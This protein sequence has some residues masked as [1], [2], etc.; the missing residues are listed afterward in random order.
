VVCCAYHLTQPRQSFTLWSSTLTTVKRAFNLQPTPDGTGAVYAS[1]PTLAPHN[2]CFALR[3]VDLST[4]STPRTVVP[5]VDVP[6]GDT[7]PPSFPG[8]YGTRGSDHYWLD[9]RTL[10]TPSLWGS[11]QVLLAINVDNGSIHNI[12]TGSPSCFPF[13]LRPLQAG[14]DALLTG[15]LC[16]KTKWAQG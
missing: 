4:L 13:H 12:S 15:A 6:S 14:Y 3:Y 1:S 10:V 8:L 9:E 2:A 16:R 7:T 11:R 5:I